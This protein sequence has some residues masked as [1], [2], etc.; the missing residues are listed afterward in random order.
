VRK[1]ETSVV[2][3]FNKVQYYGQCLRNL[4]LDIKHFNVYGLKV[5]EGLLVVIIT[6]IIVPH[7]NNH[8]T[9]NEGDLILI[10]SSNTMCKWIGSLCFVIT[11]SR[12]RGSRILG[13]PIW[14][15]CPSS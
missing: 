4:G 3:E 9:L 8:S 14:F 6:K 15:W 7:G 11:Y 1:G 12:P 5:E 13:C 2:Q 10:I